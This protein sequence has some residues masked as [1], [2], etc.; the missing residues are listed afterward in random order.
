M[1]AATMS[2]SIKD[3]PDIKA[4][5]EQT[6]KMKALIE[7][8]K[9]KQ[10]EMSARIRA[11]LEGAS[12]TKEDIMK[13][14]EEVQALQREMGEIQKPNAEL[15]S[16][17]DKSREEFE[18]LS[19]TYNKSKAALDSALQA[20]EAYRKE[21]H[22]CRTQLEQAKAD[23]TKQTQDLANARQ[24]EADLEKYKDQLKDYKKHQSDKTK[25]VLARMHGAKIDALMGSVLTGWLNAVMENKKD[26]DFDHAM[27]VQSD[28]LQAMLKNKSE[29]AR[30]VMGRMN[31]SS[32]QGLLSTI[33]NY[34]LTYVADCRFNRASQD[35]VD[36]L[37]K[38]MQESLAK[39][40]DD[41]KKV[42]ARMNE[43]TSTG[44][45][46]QIIQHW[47]DY[48][49][50]EQKGAKFK[51]ALQKEADKLNE[52]LKAKSDEARN[53]LER[54]S[55]ASAS[56]LVNS[57]LGAWKKWIF[58]DRS[59]RHIEDQLEETEKD[60]LTTKSGMVTTQNETEEL[61]LSIED[62]KK[63]IL[64]VQKEI[65]GRNVIIKGLDDELED[66]QAKTKAIQAE[67]DK[68]ALVLRD[69]L[70]RPDGD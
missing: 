70:E 24:T 35:Q 55:A 22:S 65:E 16:K 9:A 56:G 5:L 26:K 68:V 43:A 19:A 15:K 33:I 69:L 10:D 36:A 32:T 11:E 17:L 58:T 66:S 28:Q 23:F 37:N 12:T 8:V 6:E 21:Y 40:G 13:S 44:L 61:K 7:K 62:T 60:I 20:Q 34:W 51:E 52:Q 1:A 3:S 47:L 38:K 64:S 2:R 59:K 54:M 25:S 45:L 46:H 63:K 42:L 4:A 39:K 50:L 30:Q 27:K 14:K 67:F 53:V 18:L 41:A 31:A 49:A 57:C 29:K 48:M